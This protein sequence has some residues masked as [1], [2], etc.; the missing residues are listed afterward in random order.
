MAGGEVSPL[1]LAASP[2]LL[3]G[4]LMAGGEC[5]LR[6][7]AASPFSLTGQLMA[8]GEC[9]PRSHAASAFRQQG[10]SWQ[11]VS[12]RRIRLRRYFSRRLSNS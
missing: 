7:L 9:P 11:E 3:T 5:P 2:F 1:S 6:S 12:A 8:G 10:N 4:Q